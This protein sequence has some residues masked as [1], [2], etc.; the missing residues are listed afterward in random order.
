MDVQEL[1]LSEW[2][3]ALPES[4]F[5]VFHRPEALRV[6]DEYA[7]GDLKLF[8]GFRG[9]RPVGLL[10][11]IVQRKALFRLVVSPPPSL[12]IPHLGPVLMPASPKRR[13]Q[14]KL[15]RTFV[16][17][18]LERLDTESPATLV[19]MACSTAYDDPRPYTWSDYSV[20]PLFSYQL[21]LAGRTPEEVMGAFSKSLRREI[22]DARDVDVT[23]READDGAALDVFDVHRARFAERGAGFPMPREYARD[24]VAELGDRARVYVVEDGD[25][26]F[27]NGITV[28][29][30]NDAGFFWQGAVRSDYEGVSVNGL[31]HWRVIE[32]ILTDPTLESVDRYD[33]GNADMERLARYKSKFGAV[34]APYYAVYSGPMMV[35]AQKVYEAIAY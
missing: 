3:E 8:G 31:L 16:Q 17:S 21:D 24:V 30:S 25:G 4:G 19:G 29:Y 13:K 9:D 12:G 7:E 6:V 26:E 35:L 11:V 1:S 5:E 20:R 32:D 2:G 34:P 10:P 15:N 23:V 22:R 14:E 28:L 18:V 27:V 33:L